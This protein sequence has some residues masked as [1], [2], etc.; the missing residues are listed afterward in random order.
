MQFSVRQAVLFRIMA[1]KYLDAEMEAKESAEKQLQAKGKGSIGSFMGFSGPSK[2][3][4]A[5]IR[6][7]ERATAARVGQSLIAGIDLQAVDDASTLSADYEKMRVE[8]SL[9]EATLELKKQGTLPAPEVPRRSASGSGGLGRKLSSRRSVLDQALERQG[10]AVKGTSESKSS[11]AA[12]Q[13][14]DD[15]PYVL[16]ASIGGRFAFV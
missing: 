4:E 16:R 2:A 3:D 8:V 15:L 14:E 5:R 6:A 1:S 12:A 13:R 7:M 9:G 11:G 10:T